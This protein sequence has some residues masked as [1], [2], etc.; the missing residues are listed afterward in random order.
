MWILYSNKARSLQTP[1]VLLLFLYTGS[2]INLHV[3]LNLTPES[4]IFTDIGVI[5]FATDTWGLSRDRMGQRRSREKH[6][7][8]FL[9]TVETKWDGRFCF[10]IF[11]IP[12]GN[13]K[14]LILV[15]V[16]GFKGNILKRPKPKSPKTKKVSKVTNILAYW[17]KI[18]KLRVQEA[19]LNVKKK[20]TIEYC[21]ENKLQNIVSSKVYINLKWQVWNFYK[22]L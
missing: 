6:K 16:F 22:G 4:T 3:A 20:L 1:K 10:L 9:A 15:F 21:P 5:R 13:F 12:G 11:Q 2:Y 7:P 17:W 14:N 19:I 18:L 8:V